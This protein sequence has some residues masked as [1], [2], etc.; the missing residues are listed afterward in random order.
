MTSR[1]LLLLILFLFT[2]PYPAQANGWRQGV[3][4]V[5]NRYAAEA[6]LNMLKQGGNA[7]DAAAVAHLVLAVTEPYGSGIGGGSYLLHYD[8]QN[9][10]VHAWDGR[11]EIPAHFDPSSFLDAEGDPVPFQQRSTGGNPVGVPG[12]LA[13]LD[14]ALKAHGTRTLADVLQPAIR[15]ARQ[16]FTIDGPLARAI[17][18]EQGRLSQD[19]ASAALYLH[20]DGTPKAAGEQM[21]N[22]NLAITLTRIAQE[23]VE[24]FYKGDIARDIAHAVHKHPSNPGTLSQDDLANYRA[25]QRRPVKSG[26]R[27]LE[28]YGM[29][30]SSSGGLTLGLIL[31]ILEGTD[32]PS[33]T[34][35]SPTA[36]QRLA[37]AQNM[38]FADRNRYMADADFVLVPTSGLLDR[39][40]AMQ[41]RELMHPFNALVTP[42]APG[43]PPGFEE[44][45]MAPSES[46]EGASTTHLSIIDKQGNMAALTA[47]IE[48]RFGAALT[49]PARGFTLNSELTDFSPH[50]KKG[51]QHIANRPDALRRAR[52]SAL[53]EDA[54]TMGGKR[55]RSS[56]TPTL[57]LR[58]G[59][60]YL[61][62][63]SPGGSRIIGIVLN[64]L[65]N[66]VDFEMDP[67]SAVSAARM[68]ARNR[69]VD[70]EPGLFADRARVAVLEAKGLKVRK[71]RR[72]GSAQVVQMAPDGQLSGGSDPRR[73]GVV[74]GY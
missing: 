61:A 49:V 15:L 28:V 19:R 58:G 70:L 55:P 69:G 10:S 42:V 24:T 17:E 11:E 65:T 13:L 23:G 43:I 20:P 56:M 5:S 39:G 51:N 26:Y 21:V 54:T 16:G 1:S 4:S 6:A 12:S 64:V 44:A 25:V 30:P 7:M 60:P 27:G 40:Y 18:G 48:R 22:S 63:G 3:V 38:A 72:F 37:D 41:R 50:I 35:G 8:A 31:H 74:L 46:E 71:S 47:S 36:L 14:G 57:V 2:L 33:L 53:G 34:W 45:P 9:K 52:R 62:L 68:V 73:E 67:Q 66:I 32:L 59:K 29:P